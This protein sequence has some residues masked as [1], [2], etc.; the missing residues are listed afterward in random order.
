MIGIVLIILRYAH[1]Q[2]LECPFDYVLRIP[3][4]AEG[5]RASRRRDL[6]DT[7][8]HA[9]NKRLCHPS[10]G[11]RDFSNRK[12]STVALAVSRHF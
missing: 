9:D 7:Y 3:M 12:S 8:L 6:Y 5:T 2:I 10:I 1:G 4:R 11:L